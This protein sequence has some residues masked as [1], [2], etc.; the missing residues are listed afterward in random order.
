MSDQPLK[1]VLIITYYWP[2]SGGS[3]VQRWTKFAKY[4]PANGWQPVVY[5]PENPEYPSIDESLLRD[6]PEECE[7]IKTPI[8][9]PY[10]LYKRFV[11]LK[12]DDRIQTGFLSDKEKPGVLER[13][14]RWVR[15]NF[16]IPDARKY[17]IRPSIKY[18]T[19]YLKEN[20]VDVIVSSGPPH[21]MHLIAKALKKRTGIRWVA[22]FRDP[23]TNIDFYEDLMLTRWADRKHHRL[24]K[25]VLDQADSVLVVGNQMKEEFLEISPEAEVA[26]I[27]NGFDPDDTER[28]AEIVLDPYFSIAHIGSFSPARNCE[29]LWEVLAEELQKGA[30]E[31]EVK[32]KVV[33]SMD[34]SV[35]KSIDAHGLTDH[36][37]EIP[38]L[39]HDEVIEEQKKSRLL[40]L[41]VNRTKNAKG[42]VTGKI[43]E[44]MSSGRPIL[45]I[46]P[47]DGDLAH[48]LA[49]T[50]D[51]KV[52]DYED[53]EGIRK[54][55]HSHQA[56]KDPSAFTRQRLTE[57]LVKE[58]KE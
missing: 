28:E 58:L 5:T 40:L 29:M 31:E 22:D 51:V 8:T 42:I 17:W 25:A 26:V 18:L 44:Y 38:Y 3:G 35:R 46:G 36:L 7:V 30:F 11:G 32:I 15:G 37:L 52:V 1:R 10:T 39:P 45:A 16:F 47:T 57:V 49:Q 12:K 43:F 13:V 24:E 27:P 2:P 6:I 21:S 9:E 20:P 4:L 53:K 55:L 56:V 54:A 19:K 14:S 41:V 50:G 48:L 34:V 33:G 23:W